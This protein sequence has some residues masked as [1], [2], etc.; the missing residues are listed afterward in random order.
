M[1]CVSKRLLLEVGIISNVFL[2]IYT[3]IT[4]DGV[5]SYVTYANQKYDIYMVVSAERF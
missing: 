3:L 5:V 1:T 4:Y 2:E